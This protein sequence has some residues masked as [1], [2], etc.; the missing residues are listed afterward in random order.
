[1]SRVAL[2]GAGQVGTNVAQI[3][4]RRGTLEVLGPFRP[5]QRE[6]AL[7]CKADVV[8]IATTSF[9]SQVADD[10]GAAV[11][12]G[13]NVITTAEEAAYPWA[14]DPAVANRLD[15]LARG[16][17]VT[18]LGA[19]LNPG[20]AFDALVLTACGAVPEVDSLLVE[21]V[22]DVSGFGE[23][24]LRRIGV[25]H[26]PVSFQQG[27]RA[28]TVTGH[29]GFSQSMRVV[30]GRLGVQIERIDVHLEP[31]FA[32]RE[33]AANSLVVAPGRTAGFKQRYAAIS[34]NRPWFVAVF[35][36]HVAPDMIDE[37]PR[38][39]IWIDAPVGGLKLE[40]SPG[41]NPQIGSASIVANSV[42]RVIA[43]APGWTTVGELPPAVPA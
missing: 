18:I 5:A 39:T 8:V 28:G 25:G 2:Y 12:S 6:H 42:G 34:A 23:T 24:V 37:A 26:S 31:I 16:Y 17:G 9:L 21:R 30:A 27:R 19:G 7:R 41:I 35:I 33:L 11:E 32:E 13:S 20:F 36:G 40:I 1:M 4:R 29:I 15:A 22:V 38:D 10:I 14:N 43:A 3:L